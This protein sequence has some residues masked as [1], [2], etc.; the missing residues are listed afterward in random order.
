MEITMLEVT[1]EEMKSILAKREKVAK[2]AKIA[3]LA[4]QLRATISEIK[5][6]GG[7]V[8]VQGNKGYTS[9]NGNPVYTVS[10]NGNMV[11]MHF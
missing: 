6:L 4:E 10:C 11:K 1:E 7:Y 9:V 2:E 5:K 8:W 3:E